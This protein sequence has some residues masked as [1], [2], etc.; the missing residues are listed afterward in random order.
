MTWYGNSYAPGPRINLRLI[1]AVIIALGGV[2]GYFTHTS[3]NPVTGEKQHVS[4]T[5]DQ[6]M[7]L[8]LQSA[9]R[10]AAQMGGTLRP[11]DPLARLVSDV[12]QRVLRQSD[13]S[14]GPYTHNFHY[15]VL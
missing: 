13:A 1:L 15:L 9:P 3:V 6:E 14:R 7:A 2:I 5:A 8:G 10:M 12:G 11:D 4:L